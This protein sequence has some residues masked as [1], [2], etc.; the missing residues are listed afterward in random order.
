MMA[1]PRPISWKILQAYSNLDPRI[2]VIDHPTNHGL[3]AARNTGFREAR[4]AYILYI[5]S[6]DLLEPTAAEKWLWFLEGH[7][8]FAFAGGYSAG[9]GAHEYLWQSGFQDM[10]KN[11]EQNRINHVVMIRKKVL[12]EMN[13]YDEGMRDGLEDWDFWVRC[14]NKGYWGN[15][16]PEYLHWYRTRPQH[17]DRWESLQEDHIQDLRG[18]FKGTI[19]RALE[20]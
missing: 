8:E 13:G 1:Q 6:D 3:P 18:N 12:Q 14:A 7:P 5:D 10:E 19:S 15:S 16:I 11:L 20:W 2:R 4:C 9:F 17:T